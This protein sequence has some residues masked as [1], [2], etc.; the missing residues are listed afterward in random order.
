MRYA[1][2]LLVAGLILG[3]GTYF[4]WQTRRSFEGRMRQMLRVAEADGQVTPDVEPVQTLRDFG[5]EISPAE[6]RRLQVADLLA[7]RRFVLIPVVLL[8]CLSVAY[9]L[10]K[11]GAQPTRSTGPIEPPPSSV[12]Q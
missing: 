10:G 6:M 9:V 4:V 8:G 1:L 3:A 2:A 7:R 11:R 5:V 12:P